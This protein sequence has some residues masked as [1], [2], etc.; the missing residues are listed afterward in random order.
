MRLGD[1]STT[2]SSVWG[3]SGVVSLPGSPRSPPERPWPL[4]EARCPCARLLQAPSRHLGPAASPLRPCRLVPPARYMSQSLFSPAPTLARGPTA[5]ACMCLPG[6]RGGE[7][8][9]S[10]AGP[11]SGIMAD[12]A[13]KY[14]MGK[15][16]QRRMKDVE[17]CLPICAGTVSFWQGKKV[18]NELRNGAG[19]G[20]PPHGSE[21]GGPGRQRERVRRIGD[22]GTRNQPPQLLTRPPCNPLHSPRTR[23]GRRVQRAQVDGI[24]SQSRE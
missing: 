22:R 4:V 3:W 14:V 23:P 11:C 1:A 6:G 15:N 16:G 20:D 5:C 18:R 21:G 9:F 19:Q 8:Q 2:P 17:L 7:E 24:R 12:S 10:G 13:T